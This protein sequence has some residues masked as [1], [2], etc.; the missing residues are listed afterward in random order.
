MND[1]ASPFL[2]QVLVAIFQLVAIVGLV[3]WQM[4]RNKREFSVLRVLAIAFA[5]L[6]FGSLPFV[7]AFWWLAPSDADRHNPYLLAAAFVPIGVLEAWG[8]VY[9]IRLHRLRRK[10]ETAA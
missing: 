3:A 9:C 5:A 6:L 4:R 1:T 8:I 7:A 10:H 2:I